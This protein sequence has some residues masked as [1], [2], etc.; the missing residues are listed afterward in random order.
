MTPTP[1]LQFGDTGEVVT[2]EQVREKL[3][4][5]T[6]PS[7]ETTPKT[8]PVL[9]ETKKADNSQTKVENPEPETKPEELNERTKE[10]L[11]TAREMGSKAAESLR[12]LLSLKDKEAVL[13]AL[14]LK[15]QLYQEAKKRFPT[16]LAAF[17][18]PTGPES[19][20]KSRIIDKTI[21]SLEREI[22]VEH[23]VKAKQFATERKLNNDE[24]ESIKEYAKDLVEESGVTYERALEA[25]LVI[26]NPDKF[27]SANPARV[28]MPRAELQDHKEVYEGLNQ[29]ETAQA[30]RYGIDPSTAKNMKS[31]EKKGL[32]T[33]ID[34]GVVSFT[35]G[36]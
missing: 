26:V 15:P 2:L 34:N 12:L 28:E 16:E 1:S 33:N 4:A 24:F 13:E 14:R 3:A 17:E 27:R 7:Q 25:A 36:K 21:S 20:P 29:D 19:K 10:A 8:T 9:E 32:K 31:L 23:N 18:T 6:A 22:E 35:F 30:K 11:N 5:K